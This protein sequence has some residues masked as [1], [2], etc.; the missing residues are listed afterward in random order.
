MWCDIKRVRWDDNNLK[1][2]YG[3]PLHSLIVMP[4]FVKWGI[5]LSF[6]KNASVICQ[7]RR[8]LRLKR[9]TF[10]AMLKKKIMTGR[11]NIIK[12]YKLNE[13]RDEMSD[14]K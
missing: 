10:K 2:R 13:K 14:E 5:N 3:W 4:L 8:P 7:R 6:K 9:Y 1:D 11:K 12:T